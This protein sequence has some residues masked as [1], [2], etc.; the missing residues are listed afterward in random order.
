VH[1]WEKAHAIEPIRT[2]IAE[3]DIKSY[4]EAIARR[5]KII[6]LDT[7]TPSQKEDYTK[8]QLSS[9]FVE[10]NVRENPPPIEL[11]KEILIKLQEGTI[12]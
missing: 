7:L 5:Y 9:I 4:G 2:E 8:I 1:N 10:Q 6:D 3:L 12:P 11:P